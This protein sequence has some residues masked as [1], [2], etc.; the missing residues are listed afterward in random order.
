MK[1]HWT[2]R[3]LKLADVEEQITH[4]SPSGLD[5]ANTSSDQPIYFIKGQPGQPIELNLHAT[6]VIADTGVKGATKEAIMAVRN[7]WPLIRRLPSSVWHI[8]V[9]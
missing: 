6:M 5:A 4:R 8:W 9:S 2:V 1:R 3:L 7:C